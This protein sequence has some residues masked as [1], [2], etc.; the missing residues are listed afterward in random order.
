MTT[1]LTVSR[2]DIGE[3]HIIFTRS[4]G[5]VFHLMWHENGQ[6]SLFHNDKVP[7]NGIDLHTNIT[8][9]MARAEE[10]ILAYPTGWPSG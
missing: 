1:G 8:D 7:P 4:D 6:A 3:G 9:K 5:E 10:L 2:R